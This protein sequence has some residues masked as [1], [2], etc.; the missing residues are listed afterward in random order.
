[1]PVA[2]G[3]DADD[4]QEA[5]RDELAMPEALPWQCFAVMMGTRRTLYEHGVFFAGGAV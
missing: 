1:V 2:T 5:D 4:A 3:Q